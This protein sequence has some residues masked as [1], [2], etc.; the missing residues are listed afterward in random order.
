VPVLGSVVAPRVL[1]VISLVA[2]L[3]IAEYSYFIGLTLSYAF[4][5]GFL[6]PRVCLGVN[7]S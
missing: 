6:R 1:G 7:Y 3:A 2:S 4:N 5:L